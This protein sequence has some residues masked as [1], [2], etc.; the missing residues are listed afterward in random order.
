ML[1]NIQH[2]MVDKQISKKELA[3]RAGMNIQSLYNCFSLNRITLKNAE[4]IAHAL[5]C[6]IVLIDRET[7]KIY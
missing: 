2:A 6:D 1:Q 7:G 3:E 5:N 4:K